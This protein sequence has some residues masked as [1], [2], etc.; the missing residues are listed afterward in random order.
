MA[1]AVVPYAIAITAMGVMAMWL[2]WIGWPASLGAL[3]F[4]TSDFVLAAELFR[5]PADAPAR[6][7]TAPVVWWT[8]AT[9]QVLIVWGVI[10]LVQAGT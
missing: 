7:F 5:L 3:L 2:P 6:R 4:L 9:A 1:I 8:Y 10:N